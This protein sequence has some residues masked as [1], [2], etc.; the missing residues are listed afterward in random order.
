[1]IGAFVAGNGGDVD[2][3]TVQAYVLICKEIF[4]RDRN[5]GTRRM[6]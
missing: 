2:D 4:A 5:S 6:C 3:E 1:M